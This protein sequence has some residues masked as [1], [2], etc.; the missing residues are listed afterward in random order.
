MQSLILKILD[1]LFGGAGLTPR[2]CVQTMRW[3]SQSVKSESS[4][5]HAG[6]TVACF[7][8][9]PPLRFGGSG[10]LIR[11]V[12]LFLFAVAGNQFN[13][14]IQFTVWVLSW[15][16]VRDEDFHGKCPDE[17]T[18]C[19]LP[20][21]VATQFPG[22]MNNGN[23]VLVSVSVSIVYF[24]HIYII[25][26]TIYNISYY[27]LFKTGLFAFTTKLCLSTLIRSTCCRSNGLIGWR[28]RWKNAKRLEQTWTKTP[29][30]SSMQDVC[31]PLYLQA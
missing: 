11:I 28:Q 15:A 17:A 12:V 24:I 26:Y 30:S 31:Y 8:K 18:D 20:W 23:I 7:F 29:T 14:T 22:P 5:P 19:Q 21:V 2:W 9:L 16:G 13:L 6:W 4:S 3:P 25:L 27:N 1:F 10:G